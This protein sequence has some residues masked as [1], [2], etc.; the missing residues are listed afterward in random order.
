[1]AIY[2]VH[3]AADPRAPEQALERARLLRLGF[4]WPAFLLGP[5]WLALRGLWRPLALWLLVAAVAGAA[6]AR[7]FV[8]PG[9]DFWLYLLSVVYLALAGRALQGTA[10]ARGGRPL[11]DIVCAGDRYSA[12]RAFFARA[13]LAPPPRPGR[14]AAAAP[15]ANAPPHVLGLF[16]E[17]G[18]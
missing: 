5:L 8:T 3:C 12:E 14:T 1:M 10:L 15:P 16:P 11:A 18:G 2:A 4:V 7:G 6:M 17:A 9:E 13:L